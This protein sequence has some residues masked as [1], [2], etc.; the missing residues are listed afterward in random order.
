MQFDKLTEHLRATWWRGLQV[1]YKAVDQIERRTPH[2][3]APIFVS[4]I[5]ES[6]RAGATQ[7]T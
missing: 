1:E 7:A 2:A 6:P 5:A 4:E 3:K